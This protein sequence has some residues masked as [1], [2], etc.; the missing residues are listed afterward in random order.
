MP[1]FIASLVAKMV[2]LMLL[3]V[4]LLIA[5]QV[6]AEGFSSLFRPDVSSHNRD[7]ILFATIA[8]VVT[9]VPECIRE[10]RRRSLKER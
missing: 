4:A 9:A 7:L 10:F 2:F 6:F 1:K 8:G 3:P 5:I